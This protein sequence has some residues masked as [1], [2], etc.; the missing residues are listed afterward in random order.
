MSGHVK[1]NASMAGNQ[2]MGQCEKCPPG[3]ATGAV[4]MLQNVVQILNRLVDLLAN[5]SMEVGQAVVKN[6]EDF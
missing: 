3:S 6:D 2:L 1:D 4:A 5:E